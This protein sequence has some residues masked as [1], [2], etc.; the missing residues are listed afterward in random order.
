MP[1]RFSTNSKSMHPFEKYLRTNDNTL[2]SLLI[3]GALWGASFPYQAAVVCRNQAY[4]RGWFKI[5]KAAAPVI[6]VGNLTAG[7]TGKTPACAWIA[8]WMRRRAIRVAILSRGYGALADGLNDEAR[9]L[10]S[11]LPDVPHL[12]ASDR[13][14]NARLAVEELV[15]SL[16]KGYV[17]PI[18]SSSPGATKSPCRILPIS[19]PKSSGSIP[20]QRGSRAFMPR[21]DGR[22]LQGNRMS[23]GFSKAN[24]RCL[25]VRLETPKPSSIPLRVFGYRWLKKSIF[26]ITIRT[27]PWMC[28]ASS[29]VPASAASPRKSSCAP[30]RILRNYRATES[31]R[32]RFGLLR[33]NSRLS[34]GPRCSTSTSNACANRSEP[35]SEKQPVARN[36]K[37]L[38]D[39]NESQGG[40]RTTSFREPKVMQN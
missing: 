21:Y 9:E 27:A 30:A 6:S 18:W 20:R 36:K 13:V 14:E 26:Q 16:S 24:L 35:H 32:F 12:Q 22:T 23:S 10:E 1:S 39:V 40:R 31:D 2:V 7:G 15:E 34:P 17:E 33:S 37:R 5:T 4:Q 19:G 8:K 28:K 3:R 25:C 38:P 11:L 29:N